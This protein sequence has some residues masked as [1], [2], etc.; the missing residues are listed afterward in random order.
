MIETRPRSTA[1]RI[2]TL[3]ALHPLFRARLGTVARGASGSLH[4]IHSMGLLLALCL[5]STP[6]WAASPT[7]T[8]LTMTSAGAAVSSVPAH[9]VVT[10]TAT[11][12]IGSVA[13][14]PGQVNFC[15]A[16]AKL[17]SDIHLLGTAQLS[18]GGLATIKFTPGP[19]T[20][21]YRAEFVGTNT[22]GASVSPALPLAVSGVVYGVTATTISAIG[23]PGTYGLVSTVTG[24]G[25][26]F[27]PTGSVSFVDA[28]HG[29]ASLATSALGQGTASNGLGFFLSYTEPPVPQS[30]FMVAAADFNGDGKLDAAIAN[31][32][33]AAIPVSVL[34]GNGDGTMT[35]T[36]PIPVSAPQG[37][38]EIAIADFN[39]DGIPD[40]VTNL[41]NPD[42]APFG[43]P[44]NEVQILLGNGDGTFTLGQ[45]ISAPGDGFIATGD[46]NGDGIADLA[47]AIDSLIPGVP[48]T[49]VVELGQGDG[50]FRLSPTTS[51]TGV[52]PSAIATGDFNRDGR[53]DLAICN[54]GSND[55]T[56]L[57]G[58][59]DGTFTPSLLSPTTGFSPF[60]IV[61]A[62]FN[63]DG[64]VDL[65]TLDIL[66]AD[67]GVQ[68]VH[69]LLGKGDGTFTAAPTVSTSFSADNV[70]LALTVGDFN[71]DGTADLAFVS[72]IHNNGP[73]L[74]I[75]LGN[76]DGTFAPIQLLQPC[77]GQFCGFPDLLAAADFNGDGLSDLASDANPNQGFGGSLTID[78]A[79]R[80]ID[81]AGALPVFVTL[82][83]GSGTH[84]VY[85]SYPGDGTFP[86]S[87]SGTVTLVAAAASSSITLTATPQTIYFGQQV[88]LS[89]TLAPS[90]LFGNSPTGKVIFSSGA[91]PL[92]KAT[93]FGGTSFVLDTSTLAVGDD[94]LS[95]A[96]GGDAN[97][98]PST[99]A[100]VVVHVAP[101]DFALAVSPSL[102]SATQGGS[103]TAAVTLTAL[104][105]FTQ[106]LQL[107]CSGLPIN[108]ACVFS[109]TTVIVG[110]TPVTSTMTV[111]TTSHHAA[112]DDPRSP[113]GFALASLFGLVGLVSF[114]G[115]RRRPRHN[116][117]LR[118]P[119]LFAG[120]AAALA[121]VGCGREVFLIASPTGSSTFT[122]TA[123]AAPSAGT[124]ISHSTSLTLS[125][126]Q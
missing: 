100:P 109:P 1:T 92:G 117:L 83:P 63:G 87:V 52:V 13:V 17:C 24:S 50:T 116:A 9:T 38:E 59:G 11:V 98:T 121:T 44:L 80:S 48:G 73:R 46:F 47:L 85:A 104:G 102:L 21:S 72:G 93:A 35:P 94:S 114:R 107:S 18:A 29:N 25:Y 16:T 75:A 96:Y 14:S 45:L 42:I 78:L 54:A 82:P 10:L 95:A 108:A 51:A 90:V 43:T 57:L 2:E 106:T 53:L 126:T 105:S 41:Y 32:P 5:L 3:P 40:I 58:N 88:A 12:Q 30:P 19:G 86:P 55:V 56:V 27:S 49:V 28:N 70:N 68:S 84:L 67:N 118:M 15:D 112:L 120:L 79:G 7:T 66:G 61:A 74:A 71:G 123:S 62:D 37:N 115:A 122:V 77:S 64:L 20:H 22:A 97:F 110:P 39:G 8:V 76:G 119:I 23:G 34:L 33:N 99:S 6:V 36:P 69:V 89:A 65:A 113:N 101:A 4:S 26:V 103:G 91:N 125:V 81:V 60:M 111:T 31:G 124:S